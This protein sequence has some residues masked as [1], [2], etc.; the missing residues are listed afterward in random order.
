VTSAKSIGHRPA[1]LT[2]LRGGAAPEPGGYPVVIWLLLGGN[3]VV[4]AAGFAKP[5]QF[6]PDVLP[7][8]H[9]SSD[10]RRRARPLNGHIDGCSR[11]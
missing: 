11:S 7:R 4:R 8:R 9:V 10:R 6:E 5:S 3:V 1:A 2:A